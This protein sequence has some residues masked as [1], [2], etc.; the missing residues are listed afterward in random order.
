MERIPSTYTAVVLPD[1]HPNTIRAMLS[2]KS[3]QKEIRELKDDE[4]L[5]K[6]VAAPVNP[7]DIAFMQGGYNITKTTPVVPGFEGA[8][9]VLA[10]GKSH[11]AEQLLNKKVSCFAQED[12]DG[13][14]AEY[15]ITKVKN[16]IPLAEEMPDEQAACFAVNPFTAYGLFEEAR[17]SKSTAIIQNAAG[18]QVGNF[19]RKL[20]ARS[21]VDVINIVRKESTLKSLKDEGVKYVLN[22]SEDDFT[23][24]LHEM[25]TLLNA[26]IAFD[27][28]AGE[29]TGILYNNMP[30]GSRV[31]VYGGLSDKAVSH[32]EVLQLIFKNKLLKGFNLNDYILNTGR[33]RFHEISD[34]LQAMFIKGELK[35]DIQA[36]FPL[37]KIMDALKQYLGNMSKGKVLLK[38]HT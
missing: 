17:I 34:E 1:Y 14:W 38:S 29:M 37:E 32:L 9:N 21:K 33:Q 6:M 19:I 30:A 27:A 7:S 4:V 11:K 31:I 2:L 18:S 24:K 22:S 26:N 5:I 23:E 25:A 36:A 8:G 28:V 35:T 20:A 13:T 10:A 15:Y 12:T 3:E 16:C